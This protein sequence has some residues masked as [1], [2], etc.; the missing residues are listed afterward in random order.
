MFLSAC[1]FDAQQNLWISDSHGV[2][3]IAKDGNKRLFTTSSGLPVNNQTSI[4]QDRENVM[5]FTNEQS[6][7]TKLVNQQF[8]FYS[9][10]K[11]DFITTDIF[12][13]KESDSVWLYDG[14]H[15]STLLYYKNDWERYQVPGNSS[16]VAKI[17]VDNQVAYLQDR[18]KIY[19]LKRYG[20]QHI[21]DSALIYQNP[22]TV[23]PYCNPIFDRNGHLITAALGI[24]II[25]NNE[26]LTDDMGYLADQIAI[27][28]QD[29]I[30]AVN[31]VNKLFVD[32][33]VNSNGKY[34][35][36]RIHTFHD[37]LPAISPRSIT[38]DSFGNVWIG[39]RDHGLF[40][41][42]LDGWK[43]K[44]SKH[45]ALKDGLSENFISYLHCD[46]DNN[47][48]ACSPAG[49]DKIIQKNGWYFIENITR[50]NNIFQY[51]R[52]V[53][54]DKQGIVWVVTSSGLI[55]I[56]PSSNQPVAYLPHILFTE[57]VAGNKQI[58]DP[59]NKLIL[60]YKDNDI[61]FHIAAPAFIDESMI[62]FS[63]LLQGTG[64]NKWSTPSTRSEINFA[65]LPPG[66][67]TLKAKAQF[68]NGQYPE[69]AAG[70][71]FEILPPWWQTWWFRIGAGILILLSAI[72]IIREYVKRKLEKQKMLMEKQQ[73]VERERTRIATD[74]H[75][76]LGAG[77][78]RIKFLSENI[79]DNT[80]LGPGEHYELEKLKK[81]F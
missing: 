31:R 6:G 22:D 17:A 77:L 27:D 67:Y 75:D 20:Q 58:N 62:R 64:N 47:I 53:Q 40:C 16:V 70:Y 3:K 54:T 26:L 14:Y 44:S 81:L 32:S 38:I 1:F 35:L 51:V 11:P 28:K 9:Q 4:Y 29:R 39:T 56:M 73:A 72:M 30:W 52:K 60:H 66:Q 69:Q 48:W 79:A 46:A 68:L 33:L 55:R 23:F 50:G 15:H 19:K 49:L 65:N 37:E 18:F 61:T 41:F 34:A 21:F 43:I 7:L 42:F 12:A 10:V 74:M 13:D 36:R 71:S 76:D 59:K 8:E 45:L 2:V 63:Y 80:S 57:I 78:T 5:W 25:S 24:S